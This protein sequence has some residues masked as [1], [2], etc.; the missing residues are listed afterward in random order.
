MADP[1]NDKLTNLCNKIDD[2]E[3][4]YWLEEIAYSNNNKIKDWHV[5]LAS[6]NNNKINDLLVSNEFLEADKV[7]KSLPISKHSDEMYTSKIISTKLIL[8]TIKDLPQG[9]SA[10][11]NLNNTKI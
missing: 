1:D 4:K 5:K 10:Q 11:I 7:I 8:E 9:D 3:I 6:S 2:N